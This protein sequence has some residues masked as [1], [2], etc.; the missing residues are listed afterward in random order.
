MFSR[1]PDWKIL[2]LKKPLL[3]PP[4]KSSVSI[5]STAISLLDSVRYQK[6]HACELGVIPVSIP[7][8]TLLHNPERH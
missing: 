2:I 4:K 7:P 1:H 5:R 3:P 6:L 8:S